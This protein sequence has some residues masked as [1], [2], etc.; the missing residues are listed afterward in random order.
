MKTQLMGKIIDVKTVPAVPG[1]PTEDLEGTLQENKSEAFVEL[2]VV[3]EHK[4]KL[5][6]QDAVDEI[7]RY[8]DEEVPKYMAVYE[9]RRIKDAEIP[10]VIDPVMYQNELSLR[11]STNISRRKIEIS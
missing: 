6:Y 3:T 8:L 4:I 7:F 1:D 2:T 5:V 9:F 10:I 11:V